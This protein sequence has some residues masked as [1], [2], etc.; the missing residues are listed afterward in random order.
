[1]TKKVNSKDMETMQFRM[2]LPKAAS[3]AMRLIASL[4]GE[5]KRT[6][7]I[8]IALVRYL[9]SK[10]LPVNDDLYAYIGEEHGK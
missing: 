5:D 9:E 4:N 8:I 3:T 2:E 10:N 6:Y 1:M 7:A